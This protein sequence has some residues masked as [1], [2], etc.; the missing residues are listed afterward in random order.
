MKEI[1]K[2]FCNSIHIEDVGIAAIGPY[3]ELEKILKERIETGQYTEFEEKELKKRIDPKVT[4]ENVQS[5][6]VCLFPYYSG[7]Q[8]EA[9][10]AK[11]TYALD[12]HTII[13]DK[14]KLIGNFLM[15]QLTGFE[16]KIFVDNGPL[17][18]RYMAY[19]AGLGF[20]GLNS[21]IITDKYG[22]YVAIGYMLTNYPFEADKPLLR[23]CMQCG[24]CIKACPG[25]IIFGNFTMDPRGCKSYLTQKKGELTTAEINI[26]KKTNLIFGCDACQDVCP[27]NS[28]TVLSNIREFQDNIIHQLSYDELIS[29]SNKEF[30]RRYGNRAFS[31]RGRKLLVRNFEYL[32]EIVNRREG[33]KMER[34][35]EKLVQRFIK[36]AGFNTQSDGERSQCPSTIGQ[37]ELAQYVAE[38]LRALGLSEVQVDEKGY[39]T[40]TLL[41][42]GCE[43]APVVGFI[44][45]LDTSPDMAGGPVKPRLVQNYDG[46]DI[47]LHSEKSILLSPN[48][49]PELKNYIG[50][51]LLVT[52]GLTLLGA[53]D[54]AGICAIVSALEYL[55]NH[56]EI[57]HGKVRIGFTPDEEIGRGADLFEVAAFGADFAYTVDGGELGAMEYENFNA[58]NVSVSIQGRSVHPGTA[59]GKMVNALSIAAEYQQML[60][61]AQS[62]EY[63]DS[64][65]GFFHADK[66]SGNVEAASL[67]LLVRDHDRQKFE[68][69]KTLLKSM[70]EF[71][72]IKYG[73][74]TATIEVEDSYYNMREKIEPVRYIIDLACEAMEAVGVKPSIKPIRGGTDG[75]RL[76]FMGLP[77]PNLFTGGHNF[78]GKYEFLP[79]PSLLK[80]AETVVEIIRK[81]GELK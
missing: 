16:Y 11:Y 40:A 77:C 47:V 34:N 24:Q 45:H 25:K 69:R 27:H 21:H 41:A 74:G 8:P 3:Y 33:V 65:E 42:N 66:I 39:V 17:V 54:K 72:N 20:Y 59:K 80:S 81:V 71:L 13:R 37:M 63:T 19:V 10:V 38:E 7:E 56:P 50:Q 73:A 35:K 2:D 18:D 64:Y 43:E 14:L 55:L 67:H 75:A 36:Y 5:I 9:N 4:M 26:I 60:P 76:S 28:Q 53:D 61:A 32:K 1:L 79:V 46:E 70:I 6:I 31:W 62:P 49:F 57:V 30:I 15:E 58:A 48:D 68:N 22:S 51:E 52:D 12:Y 78:H 29:I 23:T 44:A